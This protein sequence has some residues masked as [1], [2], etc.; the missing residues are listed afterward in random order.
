MLIR[1]YGKHKYAK[2]LEDQV[3][4]K[5]QIILGVALPTLLRY[6]N[7]FSF[8]LGNRSILEK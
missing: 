4:G 8:G 3:L 7:W 2:I 6:I 5:R 1:H